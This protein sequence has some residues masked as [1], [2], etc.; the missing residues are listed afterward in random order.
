MTYEEKL[1]SIQLDIDG[2]S[3]EELEWY[4]AELM[5]DNAKEYNESPENYAAFETF[6]EGLMN[7]LDLSK[8]SRKQVGYNTFEVVRERRRK[9]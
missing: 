4:L 8:V 6:F 3:T 7:H 5:L 9:A 2:K 1:K